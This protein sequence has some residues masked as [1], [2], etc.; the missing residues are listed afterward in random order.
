MPA[1]PHAFR[2]CHCHY[3]QRDGSRHRQIDRPAVSQRFGSDLCSQLSSWHRGKCLTFVRLFFTIFFTSRIYFINIF[4]SFSSFDLLSISL[5]LCLAVS[6]LLT[7]IFCNNKEIF[8]ISF[9]SFLTRVPHS[10]AT[11]YCYCCCCY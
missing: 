4:C 5:S 11:F 9:H 8:L 1:L 6:Y 3:Q 10:I 2:H 7:V